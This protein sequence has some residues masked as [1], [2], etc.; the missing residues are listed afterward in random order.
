M[1]GF[2]DLQG[3]SC[4]N[5]GFCELVDWL[6]FPFNFR[7]LWLDSARWRYCKTDAIWSKEICAN[8]QGQFS[9]VS[10]RLDRISCQ[11]MSIKSMTCDRLQKHISSDSQQY[12]LHGK[13]WRLKG[14]AK[15]HAQV[16]WD[17][18]SGGVPSTAFG[19]LKSSVCG[20]PSPLS[21]C[22]NELLRQMM[23]VPISDLRSSDPLLESSFL[24]SPD[25]LERY[26]C[27]SWKWAGWVKTSSFHWPGA[28]GWFGNLSEAGSLS[29]RKCHPWIAGIAFSENVIMPHE[30]AICFSLRDSF[31]HVQFPFV[32]TLPLSK[33]LGK[34]LGGQATKAKHPA[35][36]EL[37]K[38][39]TSI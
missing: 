23:P 21:C 13:N 12:L 36:R 31:G 10:G 6:F 19:A 3:K 27:D 16:S 38:S 35:L 2:E 11:I 29:H 7:N 8:R 37:M 5:L 9:T 34:L 14:L 33:I 22:Q 25:K 24:Q 30:I 28:V 4:D 17:N 39:N 32:P 26:E 1:E 20:S 15:D 18:D